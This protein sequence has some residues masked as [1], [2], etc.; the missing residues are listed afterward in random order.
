MVSICTRLRMN[1]LKTACIKNDCTY[2]PVMVRVRSDIR[3]IIFLQ[4]AGGRRDGVGRTT[5]AKV[6]THGQPSVVRHNF[7]YAHKT[8]SVYISGTTGP[9]YG[10]RG[11]RSELQL[12]SGAELL[13]TMSQHYI[14]LSGSRALGFIHS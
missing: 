7:M 9:C 13:D 5:K 4:L 14:Y 10:S 8:K 6:Y 3:P 11:K 2:R 12:G 1:R